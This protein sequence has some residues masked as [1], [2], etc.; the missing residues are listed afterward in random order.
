MAGGRRLRLPET[1]IVRVHREPTVLARRDRPLNRFDDPDGNFGVWYFATNLRGALVEVLNRFRVNQATE[2]DLAAVDGIAG[3]DVLADDGGGEEFA[4]S[5]PESYLSSLRVAHARIEPDPGAAFVDLRDEDLLGS[6]NLEPAV[7][8]VLAEGG[9]DAFG[10]PPTLDFG[11]VQSSSPVA[12]K[13]TQAVSRAI[14]ESSDEIL[15]IRYISRHTEAE[16][17]WAVFEHA[18]REARL[19]FNEP[20]QLDPLDGEHRRAVHEAAGLLKVRLPPLWGQADG[21]G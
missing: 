7:R 16:E 5:A 8:S 10:T 12:R 15:G 14:F 19:M 9:A 18:S 3:F 4:G 11:S 1:P 13:L 2:D 20:G 6:L 21:T 17:C